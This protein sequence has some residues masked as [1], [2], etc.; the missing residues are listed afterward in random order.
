M[1]W[2]GGPLRKSVARIEYT[3]QS[4]GRT[5][6]LYRVRRIARTTHDTLKIGQQWIKQWAHPIEITRPA[7]VRQAYSRW[8]G[9]SQWPVFQQPALALTPGSNGP[10][11]S[12]FRYGCARR[13]GIAVRMAAV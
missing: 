11:S 12:T 4:T 3:D 5:G 13:P 7:W 8:T 10:G 1:L 2:Q 6:V 9:R